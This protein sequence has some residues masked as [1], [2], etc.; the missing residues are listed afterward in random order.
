MYSVLR[1]GWSISLQKTGTSLK[2]VALVLGDRCTY[3]VDPGQLLGELQHD[4]DDD[5][6]PVQRGAEELGYGHLLLHGHLH[7][8]LLHLLHVLADI[9]T[10]AQPH[11]G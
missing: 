3:S 6:L 2:K 4:R 9:V 7:A 8:F 1:Y 5:G 11:E 10:T